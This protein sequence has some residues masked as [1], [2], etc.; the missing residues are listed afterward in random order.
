M[1]DSH[2]NCT[3]PQ[4]LHCRLQTQSP[5]LLNSEVHAVLLSR[6]AFGSDRFSSAVPVEKQAG[7]YLAK[8]CGVAGHDHNACE[9]LK[10]ALVPHGLASAEVFQLINTTPR[11]AVEVYL[12]VDSLEERFGEKADE[13]VENIIALVEVYFPQAAAP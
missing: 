13:T 3:S 12:V 8:T 7:E 9:Q 4:V 6:S 1:N 10:Q 11:E 5:V 2:A